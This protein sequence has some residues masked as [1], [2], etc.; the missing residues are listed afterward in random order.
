MDER[1]EPAAHQ[2]TWTSV[3]MHCVRS[4]CSPSDLETVHDVEPRRYCSVGLSNQLLTRQIVEVASQ[5]LVRDIF[6]QRRKCMP[7]FFQIL[8]RHPTRA[9]AEEETQHPVAR[10]RSKLSSMLERFPRIVSE[11]DNRDLFEN[12]SVH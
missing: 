1:L 9:K 10:R 8:Y 12:L 5:S 6:V 3:T 7:A 11:R 4:P 2:H